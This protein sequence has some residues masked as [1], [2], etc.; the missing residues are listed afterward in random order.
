MSINNKLSNNTKIIM[1]LSEV[2]GVGK[3]TVYKVYSSLLSS[4]KMDVEDESDL[5]IVV[6]TTLSNSRN[7]SRVK[8]DVEIFKDIYYNKIEKIITE[9]NEK[10]IKIIG[11]GDDKYPIRLTNIKND[12]F[13]L[14]LILYCKGNLSPFDESKNV[15]IIGTRKPNEHGLEVT[16][17]FSEEFT[18][19]NWSVISGLALGCDTQAHQSC[20]D[21]NGKTMAILPSDLD[22]VY[23]LSNKKLAEDILDNGGVLIS[24]YFNI[25]RPAKNMFIERDRLQS[26]FSDIIFVGSATLKTGTKYAVENGILLDKLISTHKP[27]EKYKYDLNFKGNLNFIDK[28]NAFPLD[29]D[30]HSIDFIIKR[31]GEISD[32]NNNSGVSSQQTK[33]I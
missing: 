20:I 1:A 18:N 32:F 4:I 21:L 3:K 31:F 7:K 10:S 19:R 29:K 2:S 13:Q 14:P 8:L 24:E 25:N 30:E 16:K 17:F 5:E 9:A 27:N 6:E 33:L 22:K 23:P 15:A 28:W 12:K 26:A 11:I